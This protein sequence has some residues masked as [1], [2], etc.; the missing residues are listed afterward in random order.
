M[1]KR[2][3]YKHNKTN[4]AFTFIAII[5]LV[6]ACSG[7]GFL[8]WSHILKKSAPLLITV[9]SGM[10]GF[11]IFAV[12]GAVISFILRKQRKDVLHEEHNYLLNAIQEIAQGNF[13]VLIPHD[14]LTPHHEIAAAF[15]KMTQ[16]LGSLEAM[17]QD[18]ISNVSHEI[19]SPL[20]SIGGFA[21]L[22]KK[23][24]LTAEER[25]HYAEIIE[26]E[27]KRQIGRAHV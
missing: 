14:P 5:C 1:K 6:G 24:D 2:Y 13:D 4:I 16:D 10:S 27:S 21:A 26:A 3:E 15:N 17:R 25:Q 7:L 8:L 11:V 9:L 22:L 18:F 12:I 19:Q 20:T 23:D